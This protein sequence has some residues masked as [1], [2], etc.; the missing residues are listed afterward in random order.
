MEFLFE[1]FRS[2]MIMTILYLVCCIATHIY[3]LAVKWDNPLQPI[4]ILL[5]L[6]FLVQ[7]SRKYNDQYNHG[8]F[9]IP[10]VTVNMHS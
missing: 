8:N 10:R 5:G 1:K 9:W 4:T 6:A 2:L 7:R 3:W